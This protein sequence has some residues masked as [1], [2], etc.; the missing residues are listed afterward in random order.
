MP[1]PSSKDNGIIRL[2]PR[3]QR[4]RPI[5]IP[6]N[7]LHKRLRHQIRPLGTSMR[8]ILRIQR[9][10]LR[11]PELQIH[12]RHGL[13]VIDKARPP[14]H[15]LGG[16]GR[17]AHEPRR[18]P[19]ILA[20]LPDVIR[21]LARHDDARALGHV[22]PGGRPDVVPKRVDRAPVLAGLARLRPGAGTVAPAVVRRRVGAAAVVVAE[23]D[24]DYVAG[25]DE[26]RDLFEAAL[27]REAAGRTPGY[28]FVYDR[29]GDVFGEVLAPAWRDVSRE[30]CIAGGGA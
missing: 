13:E 3:L 2:Q 19:V 9:I 5:P 22:A 18:R 27:G 6:R 4:R 25:R 26:L 1:S 11:R 20:A 16:R 15:I 30:G 21:S 7:S 14:S 24:D 10:R 29:D 8:M 28:G 17:V 23:L 12:I